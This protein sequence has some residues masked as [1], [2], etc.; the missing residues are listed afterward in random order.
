MEKDSSLIA[1]D[2]QRSVGHR[3]L[4]G[5]QRQAAVP[6]PT[7]HVFTPAPSG[8]PPSLGQIGDT[9]LF[10]LQL[11]AKLASFPRSGTI[12]GRKRGAGP[13]EIRVR[14]KVRAF[15]FNKLRPNEVRVTD[16]LRQACSRV[17]AS[18]LTMT[19]EKSTRHLVAVLRPRVQGCTAHTEAAVHGP[20]KPLSK[21][22]LAPDGFCLHLDIG[23]CAGN[24]DL[25]G[26]PRRK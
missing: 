7:I 19:I 11:P 26:F 16:S 6:R 14:P 24:T 20:G 8:L 3:R 13:L 9:H 5:A 22:R 4:A 15:C 25:L 17:R 10:G 12:S 23:C 21:N 1:C 18:K 2:G